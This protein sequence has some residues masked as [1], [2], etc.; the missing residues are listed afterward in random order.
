[1]TEWFFNGQRISLEEFDRLIAEV[2]QALAIEEGEV[3]EELGV[4]RDTAGA[5]VYLRSRSRW[6]REKEAELIWR[7]RA[8]EP[9][10][11]S[12][13]LSGEF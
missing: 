4:S 3:M 10:P 13:V 2:A 6:T 7:D 11:I 9:I 1:M 12:D 8:G 5:I